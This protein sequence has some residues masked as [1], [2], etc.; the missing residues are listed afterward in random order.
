MV[1]L[2]FAHMICHAIVVFQEERKKKLFQKKNNKRTK[3]RMK[4]MQEVEQT[5]EVT[6]A[7]QERLHTYLRD[8]EPDAIV[9]NND[10]YYDTPEARLYEQ[11]VFV[12]V[13]TNGAKSTLQFKFDEPDSDKQHISCT[14]RA[15]VLSDAPLSEG[16]H[17]IF[18]HFLPTWQP[19]STWEEVCA[20]NH[21]EELTRILNTRSLYHL[22]GLTLCLD[23]VQDVGLFLE[24]EVMCEEGTDTR[25]ARTR[26]S[27]FMETIGGVPLSAGYVELALQRSK[28]AVYARGQYRL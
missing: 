4:I 19:V 14:E 27:H 11:A 20:R 10:R 18:T 21:L 8:R 6:P 22:D 2:T 5:C 24:A 13:R 7:V 15:F 12:R 17:T 16:V 1:L 23:Q 25:D 28:P 26:V 3:S 9:V